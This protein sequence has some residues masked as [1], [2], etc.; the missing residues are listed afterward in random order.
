MPSVTTLAFNYLTCWQLEVGRQA[1]KRRGKGSEE[2]KAELASD[3]IETAR[4]SVPGTSLK[5]HT[6]YLPL[7]LAAIFEKKSP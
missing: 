3:L 6:L 1:E 5:T 4:S 2:Q 7:E